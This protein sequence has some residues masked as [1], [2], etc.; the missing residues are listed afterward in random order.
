MATDWG[1]R[2]GGGRNAH[3]HGF[4]NGREMGSINA[5]ARTLR[6]TDPT[7][8]LQYRQTLHAKWQAGDLYNRIERL[9]QVPSHSWTDADQLKL[10]RIDENMIKYA[11]QAEASLR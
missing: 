6:S 5:K 8:V 3:S 9:G 11:I 4:D 7:D 2:Y 10:E 1:E